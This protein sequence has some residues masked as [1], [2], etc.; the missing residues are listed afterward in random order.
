MFNYSI[1]FILA[2]NLAIYSTNNAMVYIKVSWYFLMIA[3]SIAS[4]IPWYCHRFL[5]RAVPF[6]LI[7]SLSLSLWIFS[8]FLFLFFSLVLLVS[9]CVKSI[10]DVVL[11]VSTSLLPAEP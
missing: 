5:V 6:Y 9:P 8:C 10:I 3:I 1:M 11:A 2:L 4:A 7:L